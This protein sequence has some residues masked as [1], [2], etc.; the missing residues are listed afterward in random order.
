MSKGHER[1]NVHEDEEQYQDQDGHHKEI[2][3]A[4]A[5]HAFRPGYALPLFYLLHLLV[6]SVPHIYSS[7]W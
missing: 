1:T 7:F 4:H 3:P 5:V 6:A 2:V